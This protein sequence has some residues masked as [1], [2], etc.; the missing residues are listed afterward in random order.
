MRRFTIAEQPQTPALVTQ[1]L[2]LKSIFLAIALV[3]KY[4][5]PD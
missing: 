2:E 1:F 4:K 3:L 5:H